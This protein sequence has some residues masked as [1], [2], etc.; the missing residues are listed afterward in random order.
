[1]RRKLRERSL[2]RTTTEKSDR[3]KEK[4]KKEKGDEK[5]KGEKKEKKKRRDKCNLSLTTFLVPS[6]TSLVRSLPR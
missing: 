3:L 1:M 5:E 4:T 2:R 6:M